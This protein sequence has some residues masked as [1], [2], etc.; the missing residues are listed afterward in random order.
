V[1]RLLLILVVGLVIYWLLR[2]AISGAR[3][4]SAGGAAGAAARVNRSDP[5]L[6]C[7]YCGVHIPAA[8]AVRGG[9]GRTFCCSGHE[10]SAFHAGT[11]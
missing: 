1:A 4:A 11:Q 10:Q 7:A 6:Q 8:E 9:D 5:M 2:R 3:S